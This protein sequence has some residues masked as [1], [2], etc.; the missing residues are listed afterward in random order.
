[1]EVSSEFPSK[2]YMDLFQHFPE[3]KEFLS[4]RLE[5]SSTQP[6]LASACELILEGLHLNQKL[7]RQLIQNKYRYQ[8]SQTTPRKGPDGTGKIYL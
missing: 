5:I 6:E 4:S 8:K 2:E 3:L 1:M 7:N